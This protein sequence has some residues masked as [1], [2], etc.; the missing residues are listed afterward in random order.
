MN[1]EVEICRDLC[2]CVSYQK[3]KS[4]W[5]VAKVYKILCQGQKYY[6]LSG[7]FFIS[8]ILDCCYLLNLILYEY[9]LLHIKPLVKY[10]KC[11]VNSI[12]SNW[13][14]QV[15]FFTGTLNLFTDSHTE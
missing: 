13:G 4:L 12:V 10:L 1:P 14:N 9:V 15:T 8:K 7:G 2:T 6:R 3:F 11:F 5:S